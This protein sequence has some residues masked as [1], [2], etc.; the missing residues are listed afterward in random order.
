MSQ[1]SF[2]QGHREAF[3]KIDMPHRPAESGRGSHKGL[4]SVGLLSRGLKPQEPGRKEQLGIWGQMS[5]DHPVTPGTDRA[6]NAF[7]HA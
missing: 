6:H 1:L 2:L 5:R 3:T 4:P 7:S